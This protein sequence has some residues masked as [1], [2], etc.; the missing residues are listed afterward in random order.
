LLRHLVLIATTGAAAIA[1]VVALSAPAAP[2][3]T[4]S[5]TTGPGFT[6]TLKSGGKAVS[7]VAPGTYRI[8]V[9][10]R[11]AIH[12]F[13]LSGP[14]VN[15]VI[16]GVSFTGVRSATVKLKSGRYTFVCTPH[17]STMAG[18]FRVS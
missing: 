18:S 17:R 10:D 3:K 1:L 15:K 6:I 9:R 7:R 2:T 8:T 14:G 12:N 13:K 11:S 16:T 4:L 5:G